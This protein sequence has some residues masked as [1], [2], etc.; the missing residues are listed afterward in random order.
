M[1]TMEETINLT[2]DE[3][4]LI[5]DA[6]KTA[7][8]AVWKLKEEAYDYGADNVGSM[9]FAKYQSYDDLLCRF[10]E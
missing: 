4:A 8:R 10:G 6:I 7:M 9:L 5:R 2:Q 3:I 1:L